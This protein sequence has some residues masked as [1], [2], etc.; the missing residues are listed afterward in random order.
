MNLPVAVDAMGGDRAPGR[1]RRRGAARWPPSTA[2]RS[3]WSAAP[4]TCADIGGL[5]VVEASEV[6]DMD[7]DP[8][9]GVR[10]KKDSSLVRA[11]ELVR[12]GKASAMVSAGNTGATM[13]S[14]AAADGPHPGVSAGPPSPPPC[15]SPA[16]R[17]PRPPCCSTRAPT[18]SASRSGWCSSPRWAASTSATATAPHEPRVGLLSIGEESMKGNTLVKATHEL[19]AADARPCTSSATSRAATC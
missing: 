11:A 3:C 1:D 12:D 13:A 5:P 10:R 18:P 14:R 8:A 2:C 16:W 17:G 4:T 7:D 15:P 6:I 19:L 9:Q